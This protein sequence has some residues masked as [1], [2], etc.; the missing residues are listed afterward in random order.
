MLSG[1]LRGDFSACWVSLALPRSPPMK[2]W[3]YSVRKRI[4]SVKSLSWRP[5]WVSVLV[6]KEGG[7]GLRSCLL[8]ARPIQRAPAD[9]P[10][11]S[12]PTLVP[13]GPSC[14]SP[15]AL[16]RPSPGG[17]RGS[18]CRQAGSLAV[19]GRAP[20][21]ASSPSHNRGQSGCANRSGSAPCPESGRGLTLVLRGTRVKGPG[22]GKGGHS[23][24]ESCPVHSVRHGAPGHRSLLGPTKHRV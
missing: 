18:H 12:A 7:R 21:R 11:P 15:R 10:G 2:K 1:Q 13:A 19:P 4:L 22:P 17:D 6:R 16:R 8:G 23:C 9:A 20:V 5:V 3:A 14:S 24:P